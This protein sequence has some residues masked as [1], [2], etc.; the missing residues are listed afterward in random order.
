MTDAVQQLPAMEENAPAPPAK[1]GLGKTFRQVAGFFVKDKGVQPAA[2]VAGLLLGTT[3]L[4]TPILGTMAGAGFLLAGSLGLLLKTSNIVVD[5]ATAFGEKTKVPS[6]ALGIGLGALTSL[7]ELFV[8]GAAILAG[9]PAIGIGNITGSNIANILLILGGASAIRKINTKGASWKFNTAA[10]CGSTALFGAQMALGLL[11]P[12]AGA[13]MLGGLGFYLWK[14]YKLS[15]KDEAALAAEAAQA[16]GTGTEKTESVAAEN[17]P[18]K[19]SAE[20]KMPAWFNLVWGLGGVAGLVGSSALVVSSAVAFGA[21]V[22]ISPAVV[23]LLAVAVGTSLPEL[24]VS[25]K[26]ALKGDANMSVGNILGSNIFNILAIGGMLALTNTPVPASLNP[27]STMTGLMNTAA[28]G[29]SALL[30][31][32]LMAKT[33][34]KI[35][36]KQGLV[37]LGLYAAFAVANI[38]TGRGAGAETVAAVS[39]LP[40]AP[41]PPPTPPTPL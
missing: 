15:K 36:R 13:A 16:A 24:M 35:S 39:T 11:N 26:A 8:S 21:A 27:M 41:P 37:G 19:E 17:K 25:V 22:G 23:G 2:I 20:E 38:L 12:V 34:G 29:G 32:A 30:L 3:A 31:S 4:A 18:E 40:P 6:M 14:S 5:N 33:K 10:M 7:P 28:F 1:Q 9:N